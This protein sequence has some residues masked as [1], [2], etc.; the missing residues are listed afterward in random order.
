MVFQKFLPQK[1]D[2]S[3]TIRDIK[4]LNEI[5]TKHNFSEDVGEIVELCTKLFSSMNSSKYKN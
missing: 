2:L 4:I 3:I 1:N 5:W